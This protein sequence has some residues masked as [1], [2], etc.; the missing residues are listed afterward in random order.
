MR[1][2]AST[3]RTV[4]DHGRAAGLG[5]AEVQVVLAVAGVMVLDPHML[6]HP[7]VAHQLGQFLAEVG[8]VQPGGD[9]HGDRLQRDAGGGDGLDHR[10]QEQVVG[11]RTG[12]VAD[13]DAGAGPAL[14]QRGQ[15]RRADRRIEGVA[16]GARLIGDLGQRR[17]AHDGRPGVWGQAQG[18]EA[19][20]VGDRQVVGHGR[21]RLAVAPRRRAENLPG[22]PGASQGRLVVDTIGMKDDIRM[23]AAPHS[24]DQRVDERMRRTG[25]TPSRMRSPSP[26]PRTSRGLG[27]SPTTTR[28]R[29]GTSS[30]SSSARTTATTIPRPTASG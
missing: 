23:S 1:S 2:S 15:R 3:N 19:A 28:G 9:Q 27:P 21:L 6:Q 16:D 18:D 11:H 14:G 20:A 24:P 25:R 26:I 5:R 29:T 7:G 8:P 17:L 4:D 22:P 13:Q 10:P 30:A 12:D